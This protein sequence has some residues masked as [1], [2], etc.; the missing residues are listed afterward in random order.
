MAIDFGW[1]CSSPLD[2]YIKLYRT[3]INN[4]NYINVILQTHFSKIFV[5]LKQV[6]CIFH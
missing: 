5:L 3:H 2:Q 1:M 4:L 6:D